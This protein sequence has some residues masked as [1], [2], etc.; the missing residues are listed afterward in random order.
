M[1]KHPMFNYAAI[2]ESEHGA[3]RDFES[4]LDKLD[5]LV[6]EFGASFELLSLCENSRPMPLNSF[7]V[8]NG[9]PDRATIDKAFRL[10]SGIAYKNGA[11]VIYDIYQHMQ[12][13]NKLYQL[14]NYLKTIV[15]VKKLKESNVLFN[16][17][18]PGFG[19]LRNAVAHS[20]EDAVTDQQKKH[21]LQV[22]T[23][24]HTWV[25]SLLALIWKVL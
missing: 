19:L 11:L 20:G 4:S 5:S 9:T 8:D 13:S 24:F 22:K 15:D 16:G 6:E 21:T 23:H 18:F 10:W 17:S 1:R 3:I 7:I 12:K 25:Y 14:S 2:P